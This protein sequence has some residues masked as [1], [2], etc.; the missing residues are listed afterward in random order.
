MQKKTFDNFQHPFM[1]K[2]LNKVGLKGTYVNIIKAKYEKPT[3]NIIRNGKE[4]RA[5]LQ[6]QEKDKD[7]HSHHFH[8]TWYCQVLSTAISCN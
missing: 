2:T 6:D 4:L 8:S 7:V 1:I 5:F 3:T